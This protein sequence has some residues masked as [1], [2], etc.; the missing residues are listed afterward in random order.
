MTGQTREGKV[1]KAL[2]AIL[3]V[4]TCFLPL[5]LW[6]IGASAF[7]VSDQEMRN[8]EVYPGLSKLKF[9]EGRSQLQQYLI[10]RFPGRDKALLAMNYLRHHWLDI[11]SSKIVVGKD[12]WLFYAGDETFEDFLGL[13][14]FSETELERWTEKRISRSTALR[15]IGVE[16][17]FLVAPNKSTVYPEMLPKSIQ[18]LKGPSRLEQI[19]SVLQNHPN[20]DYE[21]LV[22]RL[23]VKKKEGEQVY[24]KRDSHFS[25]SGYE[26]MSDA[27]YRFADSKLDSFSVEN[28]VPWIRRE[29]RNRKS[30]GIKLLGLSNLMQEPPVELIEVEFPPNYRE[31]SA[32]WFDRW[33]KF[34]TDHYAHPLV[35]ERKSGKGTVI[36][37]GDSFLR[38]SGINDRILPVSLP[39][40]RCICFWG[41]LP[42]RELL[43][44]VEI[45][46]PDLVIEQCVERSLIRLPD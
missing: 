18:L 2:F 15:T 19:D 34:S 32:V 25:A 39:F 44:Y 7:Q 24:W 20:I 1:E 38:S 6:C 17:L 22:N 37:M 43:E 13:R 16:Y 4:L 23:L 3:F 46:K 5:A 40:K 31:V 21:N 42:L 35:T 36:I 33:T 8:V 10:D 29:Q 41:S 26:V 12:D 27:I 30:D 28:S 45:E 11:S 9:K 14:N